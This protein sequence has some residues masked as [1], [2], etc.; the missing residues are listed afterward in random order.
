MNYWKNW[1]RNIYRRQKKI[2]P[3][4][5]IKD[6]K[7]LGKSGIKVSPL[8]FGVLTMGPLQSSL[9]VEEGAAL[10]E[11]ALESGINFFDTAESYGTYPYIKKAF[12]NSQKHVIVASKSYAYTREAMKKSVYKALEE[13]GLDY[14]DIFLLHEQES[15]LTLKGGHG[16]ALEYLLEAKEEG[17]VRAVGLST[18]SPAG[19]LAAVQA[20]EVDILHPLINVKGLGIRGGSRDEM[21]AAIEKASAAGVGIYGM[22]PLGGGHLISKAAE[23]FNYVLNLP[24]IISTAVG[25][26]SRDE[27]DA[28][29]YYLSGQNPPSELQQKL[30]HQ[31]RRLLI[32]DWCE[33]CGICV[34][35]CSSQALV[36][37][38]SKLKV[39][40]E[41]CIFCGYCGLSC[42]HF[43]LKII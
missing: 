17:L 28:N 11:H 31:K 2:K 3:F 20:K 16:P 37:E 23:A 42:P 33:G 13:M 10:L 22:K 29:C 43:C 36:L 38:D 5:N 24:G 35:G 40:P 18:H 15:I 34:S 27:I 21:A 6:R 12:Q 14:I 8:C 25:M 1:W 26:Q 30:A 39:L 9:P 32:Q 19:A 7:P 4:L 41:K